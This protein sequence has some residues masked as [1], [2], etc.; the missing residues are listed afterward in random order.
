MQKFSYKRG[1]IM[2]S[3]KEKWFNALSYVDEKYIVEANPLKQ[4]YEQESN[5]SYNKGIA[6]SVKRGVAVAASVCVLLAVS[7]TA[8]FVGQDKNVQTQTPSCVIPPISETVGI[9]AGFQYSSNEPLPSEFCAYK[10]DTNEFDIDNVSLTFFYGGVFSSD[11]NQELE[12]GRNIPEFDIYFGDANNEP[13]YTIAHINENFISEKYRCDIIDIIT[14]E[15]Q[16]VKI[17]FNYSEDIKIPK[18]L[19]SEEQGV[20]SFCIS[21]VNV[22]EVSPENRIITALYI[23]YEVT[24]E[25]VI[26]SPWNGRLL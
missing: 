25:K 9:E 5:S 11:I 20:I 17:S 1:Y 26:L 22:N 24:D 16:S 12:D 23:N 6:I 15:S 10:S 19:F 4:P 18:S 2:M 21:G 7:L 13:I 3:D 8:V 14:D